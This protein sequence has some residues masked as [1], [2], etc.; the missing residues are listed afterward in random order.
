MF[1]SSVFVNFSS[2]SAQGKVAPLPVVKAEGIYFW[3]ASGTTY[4][5]DGSERMDLMNYDFAYSSQE[6]SGLI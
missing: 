1:E 3:D 5:Q 2:W 6:I 4:L